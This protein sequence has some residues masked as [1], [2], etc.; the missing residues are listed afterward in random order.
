MSARKTPSSWKSEVKFQIV[1]AGVGGQGILFATR[2]LA[3]AALG[4]GLSV[5]GSETH[6]MS[7]RGGSVTSHLKIGGFSSPLV[8]PA[9]A[10]F[11]IGLEVGEAYRCLRFLR[12]GSAGGEGGTLFVNAG[13][14]GFVAPIR[15][16]M[17]RAKVRFRAVDAD[18]SARELG[19]ALVANL[20]VLG[21]AGEDAGF[22]FSPEEL[23]EAVRG[24][25]PSRFR[26]LNLRALEEGSIARSA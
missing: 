9:S 12:P 19:S 24:V 17:E 21:F 8:A 25:S 18:S 10:D 22:P 3:E 1:M 20:I 14:E 13:R 6:G 7:Q 4:R 15:E 23:T 11:L 16:H 2:V 26:D 5:I